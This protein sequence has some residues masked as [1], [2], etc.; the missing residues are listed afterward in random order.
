MNLILDSTGKGTQIGPSGEL[1]RLNEL[2]YSNDIVLLSKS[3]L[4]SHID[5]MIDTC[6]IFALFSM[7][8][9]RNIREYEMAPRIL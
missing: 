9:I 1:E 2:P 5:H 7:R 6:V 3:I 8:V 4:A